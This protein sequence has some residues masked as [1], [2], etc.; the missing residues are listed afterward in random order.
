MSSD[1]VQGAAQRLLEAYRSGTPIDPLTPEFAPAELSTAYRIAQAQVEQWE[2]DGDSVKGH[3]VGLASAAIQRQMG[4]DQPDFGHLTASMFHLEHQPI[5]AATYIQPRIEPETAF[6]LGRPLTG[7]GVTIADAVRAV[8][9][10]LPALEIVDSRIRDWKIGIFDTIADNASSG[11]VVLGSRPVLLRD[12]DLRLT[13]CTLHINGE[14]VATGAGGAVLGSP[15]NSL[16][17]LA[18]TVGPLG[19]TLEPGHVVLPGSMTKAFPISPGD[20]IVANMSGLGS[21][22]AI[23]GERAEQ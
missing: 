3:K 8:E 20:S 22:S 13:G 6:V 12:V 17:W 9:F 11:G 5:P 16:V 7:P 10:V 1:Q 21:V 19:V 18:N 4:V 2:K 14:L 23:L 15:L